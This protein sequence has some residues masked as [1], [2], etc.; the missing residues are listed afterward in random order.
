MKKNI[1]FMY[2]I[3]LLQ[4]MVF[5]G[6]IATLYRQAQGVSVFQITLIESI[7][8]ALSILLEIPWGIVADKIGYRKT[9]IYCSALYFV[10]KLI[11]WQATA[12]TGFLL[13][14]IL[15]SVV[16]AGYS[17][18]DFSILYLSCKKEESQKVFGIYESMG[19]LGLLI[20]AVVFS[21]V[22]QDNYSLAGFFTV[23]SYGISMILSFFLIEVKE[24]QGETMQLKEFKMAWKTVFQNRYF[25]IFLIAVA[26]LSQTHQTITVFLNQL[27]YEYCGM[28]NST[29]GFVYLIATILGISGTYSS[30]ITK[31]LGISI[32]LSL[33]SGI[34]MGSCFLLAITHKASYSI[35]GVLLLRVAHSLFQPLQAEIQN[36]QIQSGN[37]ATILSIYAMLIDCIAIGTNFIFGVL[38]EFHLSL[39][40]VF[41][42]ILCLFS[43]L[44]L[45][46]WYRHRFD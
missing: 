35:V 41:G 20:A 38:S 30:R 5:Y 6:P 33:F 3:A 45:H 15:L 25:F 16:I 28:S 42:G 17:G 43:F 8:L 24:N 22:I 26:L 19:T 32:S 23:I 18:V 10:S 29:I 1:Y 14:R 34:A 44:F 40:F 31:K 39:A 9:M 21:T 11:F 46:T 7:S 13:E 37:R 12:F 36:K 2:A 4:G 27:Q